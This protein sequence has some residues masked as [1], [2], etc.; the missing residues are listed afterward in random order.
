VLV[1]LKLPSSTK[2]I[3]YRHKIPGSGLGN[4]NM[5]LW[6]DNDI[7]MKMYISVSAFSVLYTLAGLKKTLRS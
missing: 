5:C 7:L 1:E 3:L 6:I 2:T 4:L